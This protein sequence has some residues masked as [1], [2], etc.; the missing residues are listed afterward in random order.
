MQFP[1]LLVL[2][3]AGCDP[4]EFPLRADIA[5]IDWNE[6]DFHD[7]ACMDCAC[8]SGCEQTRFSLEN[9]SE[10]AFILSMPQT[11]DRD[12]ICLDG[13][14]DGVEFG[15]QNMEPGVRIIVDV[16]V[17]KYQAGELNSP[18]EDPPREV[19]GKL[20][21]AVSS[22]DNLLEV[23]WSYIPVRKQGGVDTAQ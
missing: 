1:L 20:V 17:C 16:S 4:D 3:L 15:E 8:S 2:L 21:F 14:P 7:D 11:H 19:S 10:D 22:H 5:I 13:Y 23:P 9:T 6:V 12:H 18:G